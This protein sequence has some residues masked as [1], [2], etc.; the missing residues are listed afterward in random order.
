MRGHHGIQLHDV[1]AGSHFEHAVVV[2]AVVLADHRDIRQLDRTV[3]RVHTEQHIPNH[4]IRLDDDVAVA[5]LDEGVRVQLRAA[6]QILEDDVSACDDVQRL[7]LRADGAGRSGDQRDILIRSDVRSRLCVG[8]AVHKASGLIGHGDNHLSARQRA[9]RIGHPGNLRQHLRAAALA[10]QDDASVGAH[11]DSVGQRVV[12]NAVDGFDGQ[13]RLAAILD[14]RLGSVGHCGRLIPVRTVE[15][16]VPFLNVLSHHV[17]QAFERHVLPLLQGELRLNR[18]VL[19]AVEVDLRVRV[20]NLQIAR[21]IRFAIEDRVELA[22]AVGVRVHKHEH[23]SGIGNV[24]IVVDAIALTGDVIVL[25]QRGLLDRKIVDRAVDQRVALVAVRLEESDSIAGV[26]VIRVSRLDQQRR[27]PRAGIEDIDAVLVEIDLPCTHGEV[28]VALIIIMAEHDAV[29][30]LIRYICRLGVAVGKEHILVKGYVNDTVVRD[31]PRQCPSGLHIADAIVRFNRQELPAIEAVRSLY[32]VP[33]TIR[34]TVVSLKTGD[35]QEV[36]DRDIGYTDHFIVLHQHHCSDEGRREGV[37]P[38]IDRIVLVLFKPVDNVLINID[39][40]I[41]FIPKPV[42]HVA[43]AAELLFRFSLAADDV[44]LDRVARHHQQIGLGIRV[45]IDRI[46]G[47]RAIR[48]P[49]I[50]R[51]I[52]RLPLRQAHDRQLRLITR[53]FV[54]VG[55]L[56]GVGELNPPGAGAHIVHQPARVDD[57][58]QRFK[59]RALVKRQ[60][61]SGQVQRHAIAQTDRD[62]TAVFVGEAVLAE[63][64]GDFD[65]VHHLRD[66]HNLPVRRHI[67]PRAVGQQMDEY[68]VHRVV[69]L[70]IAVETRGV[71]GR[72]R[73]QLLHRAGDVLQRARKRHGHHDRILEAVQANALLKQQIVDVLR[74]QGFHAHR[75]LK[76]LA[77]A[78][79][80]QGF[81][82]LKQHRRQPH[83]AVTGRLRVHH[84]LR[85]PILEHERP[86]AILLV[87]ADVGSVFDAQRVGPYGRRLGRLRI[88]QGNAVHRG[89]VSAGF[90]RPAEGRVAAPVGDQAAHMHIARPPGFHTDGR[91][92]IHAVRALVAV[93]AADLGVDEVDVLH[94]DAHQGHHSVRAIGDRHL[95]DEP[96]IV[97]RVAAA[98]VLAERQRAGQRIGKRLDGDVRTIHADQRQVLV[99]QAHLTNAA[100]RDVNRHAGGRVADVEA[101]TGGDAHGAAGIHR[102]KAFCIAGSDAGSAGMG[103]LVDR[104]A[105]L[106]RIDLHIGAIDVNARSDGH[107]RHAGAVLACFVAVFVQPCLRICIADALRISIRIVVDVCRTIR[108]RRVGHNP[109][110]VV[111]LDRRVGN[112]HGVGKGRQRTA[113]RIHIDAQAASAG[114]GFHVEVQAAEIAVDVHV[115]ADDLGLARAGL[116]DVHRGGQRERAQR[117]RVRLV[118]HAGVVDLGVAVHIVRRGVGNDRHVSEDV[119]QQRALFDIHARIRVHIRIS[120]RIADRDEGG[121]VHARLGVHVIIVSADG[122]HVEAAKVGFKACAAADGDLDRTRERIVG[123]HLAVCDESALGGAPCECVHPGVGERLHL[124]AAGREQ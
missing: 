120:A 62:H 23:L 79:L 51:T 107:R 77:A 61:A 33:V 87:R 13:V 56:I 118:A 100:I 116:T 73:D 55:H 81:N 14:Q 7:L 94:G 53:R 17:G 99:R 88:D 97:D 3:L 119:L 124:D 91:R 95:R 109:H 75:R 47:D 108:R 46:G 18:F 66:A 20:G 60:L 37:R 2:I 49:V 69:G 30:I 98:G 22:G 26:R 117:P 113:V 48:H 19:A 122:L 4:G 74:K 35:T 111:S 11:A 54:G 1:P 67:H 52:V 57:G 42:Q 6:E 5:H 90:A 89:Q 21:L 31:H 93:C 32:E 114:I 105:K 10:R 82:L 25:R 27:R 16:P 84:A 15:V 86:E 101:R 121:V 44:R 78:G 83:V 43:R 38:S 112:F 8:S 64:R 28:V 34:G 68:V 9:Q 59:R 80:R 41:I 36:I 123:L 92:G 115:P 110:G 45:R 76:R 103:V 106:D 96:L 102:T 58:Q 72:V 71:E 63:R 29:F 39:H 104:A 40:V 12:Q 50:G 85:V 24:Q 70:Q 65:V